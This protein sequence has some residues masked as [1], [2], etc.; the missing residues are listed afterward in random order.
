M[1]AIRPI[2]ANI[3]AAT[4]EFTC[5][6]CSTRFASLGSEQRHCCRVAQPGACSSHRKTKQVPGRREPPEDG[7]A[8]QVKTPF[9]LLRCACGPILLLC[10][11]TQRGSASRRNRARETPPTW[12]A[13]RH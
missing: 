2:R 5:E 1:L 4:C 10:A 13:K 6:P 12:R 9:H 7:K 11:P 8:S 3:I